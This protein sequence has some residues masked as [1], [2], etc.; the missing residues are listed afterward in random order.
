[1]LGSLSPSIARADLGARGTFYRLRAGP[2]SSETQ[3]AAL[4]RSL[5]SRGTPCLIIRPGS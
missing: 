4:C 3:A 1:M 2:L 5:S